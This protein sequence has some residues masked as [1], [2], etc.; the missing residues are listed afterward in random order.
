MNT[1]NMALRAIYWAITGAPIGVGV[2]AILSIG[3]FLLVASAPLR[4]VSVIA[5]SPFGRGRSCW[6]RSRAQV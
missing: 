6:S 5:V 4:V 1:V 2:I 3:V